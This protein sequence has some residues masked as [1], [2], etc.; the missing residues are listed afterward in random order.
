M[1]V[2]NQLI[3]K[4]ERKKTAAKCL[5]ILTLDDELT[6]LTAAKPPQRKC[7][8][9]LRCSSLMKTN[10]LKVFSCPLVSTV[11][12]ALHKEDVKIPSSYQ[13]GELKCIQ[14]ALKDEKVDSYEI[15]AENINYCFMTQHQLHQRGRD[16][17][18]NHLSDLWKHTQTS[19]DNQIEGE[20]INYL[21]LY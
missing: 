16:R 5:F 12:L 10:K 15:Q 21:L 7:W 9:S 20:T 11:I 6:N 19:S 18:S 2:V 13:A 4:W 17:P 8:W 14:T 3:I 1:T